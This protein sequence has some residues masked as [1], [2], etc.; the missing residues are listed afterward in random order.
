MIGDDYLTNNNKTIE[1]AVNIANQAHS[2]QQ[3]KGSDTAYVLHVLEAGAITSSLLTQL[4]RVD[5]EVV[6]ASIL[7]DTLE[8]TE[9]SIV[10]LQDN[11]SQRTVDLIT[12]QSEDKSKSWKKRKQ[13][14]IDTLN[15]TKDID[16][17]IVHL[18]DKLSNMRS[19]SRDLDMIDDELWTRFN[20]SRKS[21]H[22]WYYTSIGASM[23]GLENTNEYKEFKHLTDK[24]FG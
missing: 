15:K 6:A 2:G 8:D 13:H 24:V 18:A 5:P 4:S 12:V 3:R 11:F 7:H 23:V 20:E 9:L 14:T 17:L 10:S 19:I 22:G 1:N 21:E 16:V